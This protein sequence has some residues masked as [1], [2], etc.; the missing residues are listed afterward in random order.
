[1]LFPPFCE[2]LKRPFIR[3]LFSNGLAKRTGLG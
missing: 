3:K 2:G 1:M